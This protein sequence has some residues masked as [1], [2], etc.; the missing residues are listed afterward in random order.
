[1]VLVGPPLYCRGP[2]M[3]S[4]L[5]KS[6]VLLKLQV[7]SL[8]RLWPWEV[9][10]PLQFPPELL[11]A[12]MLFLRVAVPPP[13]LKMPPPGDPLFPLMVLLLIVRLLAATPALMP[14]PSQALFPLMVLLLIVSVP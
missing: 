2:S 6:P 9:I 12:T 11:L 4:V 8:L 7:L 3:G 13:P 10:V 14:P 5:F 1:M